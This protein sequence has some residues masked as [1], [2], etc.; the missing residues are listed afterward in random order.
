MARATA[1]SSKDSDSEEN[2]D[3]VEFEELLVSDGN[4]KNLSIVDRSR[5]YV[6]RIIKKVGFLGILLCASIPNPLFDLAGITCGH[7]LVKFST[8]F[9]ATLI[10]KAIIKMHI[11][12]L[13]VMITFSERHIDRLFELLTYIP[14]IGSK[15]GPLFLEWLDKEKSKL[16]RKSDTPATHVQQTESTLSFVL[17]KIV[18][19]MILFFIVSIVNALAQKHYK[20]IYSKNHSL[21]ENKIAND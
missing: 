8:F 11:Q 2:E 14:Y 13:F 12:M 17:N 4:E 9:G 21:K 18:V 6:F 19:L 1:L 3:L 20:R 16:H 5:L 15:L 10:G 7:F